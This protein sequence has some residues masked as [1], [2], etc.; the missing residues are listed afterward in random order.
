MTSSIHLMRILTKIAFLYFKV[1]IDNNKKTM[2]PMVYV[3]I[4][5]LEKLRKQLS[6]FTRYRHTY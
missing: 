6:I 5:T 4:G 3:T 2:L 1:S